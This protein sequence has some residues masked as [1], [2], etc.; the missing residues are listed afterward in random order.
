MANRVSKAKKGKSFFCGQKAALPKPNVCRNWKR[1]V[2]ELIS[3]S[4][5]IVTAFQNRTPNLGR[6]LNLP[7]VRYDGLM[8][9]ILTYRKTRQTQ[10]A[11]NI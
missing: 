2:S 11:S 4:R 3:V 7:G 10:L 5:R 6:N 8:R 9:D 1:A